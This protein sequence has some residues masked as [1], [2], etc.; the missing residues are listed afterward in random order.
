[1]GRTNTAI[2][3]EIKSEHTTCLCYS[4]SKGLYASSI[5]FAPEKEILF[6]PHGYK[7]FW[8]KEVQIPKENL[9]IKIKTN[10]G[11]GSMTYMKAIVERDGKRLLDFDKSKF[12]VLNNSS[13]MTLDV[14]HYAW[15]KLFGK[16]ISISK[17]FAPTQCSTSSISYI[18]EIDNILSKKEIF[19]KSLF[20]NEK[21]VKWSG[22]YIVTLFAAKK[23]KDLIKGCQLAN[24]TDEYFI[25]KINELCY[26]WL[27][28]MQDIN[29]DLRDNRTSQLSDCLFAIHEFMVQN[30]KG[31]DFLGYFIPKAE[32]NE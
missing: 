6:L 3:E 29:I 19:I 27:Q 1:M 32:N 30:E 13:V 21:T 17:E 16:I 18:E 11:Y 20:I 14:E 10:F 12:Y 26:K 5:Y 2:W 23:I 31:V 9:S 15:E 22:E 25:N 8:E 7:G 4:E 24:I 28:K